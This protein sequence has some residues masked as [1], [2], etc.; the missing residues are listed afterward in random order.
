MG[1]NSYIMDLMVQTNYEW[2]PNVR[3]EI[4][5]GANYTYHMFRPQ[6]ISV[7]A[8]LTGDVELVDYNVAPSYLLTEKDTMNLI[9]SPASNY[10]YSSVY[11]VWR[12]DIINSYHKVIDVLNQVNGQLFLKR[13]ILANN[14][15]KNTYENKCIIINYSSNPYNY[16]GQEVAALSSEVFDL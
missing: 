6:V 14:V 13:E 1:Y 4:H 7:S 3:H 10:I 15:I 9:D 11:D 12:E 8:H 2:R 5:F 16:N